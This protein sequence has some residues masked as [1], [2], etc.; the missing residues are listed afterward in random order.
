MSSSCHVLGACNSVSLLGPRN[1]PD[2]L[3]HM[4]DT[5]RQEF[6]IQD[7]NGNTPADIVLSNCRLDRWKTKLPP[8]V[9]QYVL[10]LLDVVTI[11][12]DSLSEKGRQ[13][14]LD[15]LCQATTQE[16]TSL[17]TQVS[18]LYKDI[19]ENNLTH[20]YQIL[21]NLDCE[22][23]YLYEQVL[24]TGL[25]V[26]S[27]QRPI[28]V[29]TSSKL[30]FLQTW[31]IKILRTFINKRGMVH[32]SHAVYKCLAYSTVCGEVLVDLLWRSI[33]HE[34]YQQSLTYLRDLQFD[35]NFIKMDYTPRS[36][37]ILTNIT[38]FRN[39]RHPPISTVNSLPLPATT[40][41]NII[42]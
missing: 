5:S 13:D 1:L 39:L 34:Q 20:I 21:S 24:Y 31:I 27:E 3:G 38:V 8:S 7:E 4:V 35:Y 2:V 29:T 26:L 33:S 36:L 14:L 28:N 6:N 11:A 37:Q 22:D 41:Q 30:T 40:K 32:D 19:T 9:I 23:L 25:N 16:I 17:N 12:C 42:C 15:I 18:V 10:R